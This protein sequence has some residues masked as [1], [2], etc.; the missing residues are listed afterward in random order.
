MA[1]FWLNSHKKTASFIALAVFL[2]VF[3]RYLKSSS[4]ANIDMQLLGSWLKFD[5][6][7]NY[8]IAFSLPLGGIVLNWLILTVIVI[9]AVWA[10]RELKKGNE[11]Q[12]E[13]IVAIVA[14]AASNLFDRLNYGYVID[15]LDLKYFTVFNLA[16]VMI[17]CGVAGLIWLGWQQDPTNNK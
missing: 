6:A 1:N 12:F 17:F 8:G 9:L 10:Q 5:F 16:D 4:L 14:G 7:P 11:S 2:T 3:D 15:Y 13:C